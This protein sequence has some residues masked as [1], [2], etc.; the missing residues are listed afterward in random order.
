MI[1]TATEMLITSSVAIG[2]VLLL[3]LLLHGR[4][5]RRLQYTLWLLI[6]LRLLLPFSIP[7]ATSVMNIPAVK[8]A[9]QFITQRVIYITPDTT[10][11]TQTEES[12]SPEAEPSRPVLS[13]VVAIWIGGALL[14]GGWFTFV[15]LRFSLRLRS[16]RTPLEVD[17][18]PLPVYRMEGLPS[19]CLF[20][21]FRPAIYL[22]A[23]VAENPK[24]QRYALAHEICHWRQR[25][26]IWSMVRVICL[27]LYWFDPLVWI[28]AALSK[29]DCER[30]CD[31]RV[32]QMLGEEERLAYGHTLV[33]LVRVRQRLGELSSTATTMTAGKRGLRA[34]I[35]MIVSSPKT[36]LPAFVILLLCIALLARFAFTG[37]ASLTASQALDSLASSIVYQDGVIQFTLPAGY[38]HGEDWNIL[39]AGR[40]SMGEDEGMSVHLFE[41]E[42]A[43]HSW[44]PGTTYSVDLNE[45]HYLELTLQASFLSQ[46]DPVL[47][48]D[49]LEQAG[50]GPIT[51]AVEENGGISGPESIFVEG[52]NTVYITF[53]AYQEGRNEAT[54]FL[55]DTEPFETRLLLPDRWEVHLP[56]TDDRS[57]RLP[58]WTLVEI[59]DGEVKVGTIGFNRYEPYEGTDE[60]AAEDWYKTVYYELRLGRLEIWDPYTPVRTYEN[61]ESGI[62]SV[63]YMDPEFMAENPDVGWAAVPTIDTTGI[64]CYNEALTAYVGLKFEADYPVDEETI[65]IIAES[66]EL[67]PGGGA[68]TASWDFGPTGK[69][70]PGNFSPLRDYSDVQVFDADGNDIT[71]ILIDLWYCASEAYNVDDNTLF[72][73]GEERILLEDHPP[74]WELLNYDETVSAIFTSNALAQYEASDV[75]L[76]QKTDDGRVWRLGPWKTGYSYGYALTDLEAISVEPSSMTVRATY[77][78]NAGYAGAS[79]DPSYVPTYRTI[80]FSVQKVDGIWY[81]D[82]Y[83][84]PEGAGS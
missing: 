70:Y 49:L 16:A 58:L 25:D 63:T 66:I 22:T 14:V 83:T 34:R 12:H 40:A 68:Q 20:G 57:S 75:V 30:A 62:A 80:D 71:G 7:A 73:V 27:A 45:T 79:E 10:S 3:R 37:G 84:F 17:S 65:G 28:A 26:H 21:F 50:G 11:P 15:N 81:I 31:E 69:R 9:D 19:P 32:V 82:D 52:Y 33:Q 42:N 67:L 4:V 44:E 23:Q 46:S 1:A 78:T 29:E 54:S 36:A 24:L 77:E 5:S 39:V 74:F 60:V 8:Q 59:Y 72:A 6:A 55:Y 64:L 35:E 41:E 56:D 13:P 38:T 51:S 53:P 2:V 18:S 48:V 47:T 43:N 76:I 61:G